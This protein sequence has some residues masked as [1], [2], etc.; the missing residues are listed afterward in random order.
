MLTRYETIM[1]YIMAGIDW[2]RRQFLRAFP[3]AAILFAG[4]FFFGT[5]RSLDM[6]RLTPKDLPALYATMAVFTIAVLF[7][8]VLYFADKLREAKEG[9]R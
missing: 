1:L 3:Y 5:M 4:L 9:R 6:G 7:Y 2:L 8:L